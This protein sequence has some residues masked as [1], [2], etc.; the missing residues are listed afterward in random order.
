[1]AHSGAAHKIASVIL[2]FLELSSAVI[3]LG[4]LSRFAYMISI[5]GVHLD[6]DIVYAM[7]VAGIG[8]IYSIVFCPPFDSLFLSFPFDFVLFI[9]W[10]VAAGLLQTQTKT[11]TCSANWYY[12]YW[13]YY[14]GRYW[15][16]GPVGR[17]TI[18]GAGCAQWRTV[19]AFSFIA[20][21]LHLTS[22]IL[23]IYVFHNYIRV[24]DTV[25]SARQQMRKMSY[26]YPPSGRNRDSTAVEAGQ[27]GVNPTQP[28]SQV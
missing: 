20:W 7:V 6:G 16:V 17:V 10:I 25:A 13:G 9:M 24:K 11:H 2:R 26:S 1:M 12:D 8:I 3:V 21:F 28:Q 23:G 14:W 27:E 19:L 22:G 5:A 18:N 4:I 15:T